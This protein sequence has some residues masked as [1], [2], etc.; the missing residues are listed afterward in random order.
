MCS[1]TAKRDGRGAV[2]VN[3]SSDAAIAAYV[4]WGAYGAS[5]AGPPGQIE[6]GFKG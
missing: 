5:K 6:T 4:G 3:V 1:D 2:V